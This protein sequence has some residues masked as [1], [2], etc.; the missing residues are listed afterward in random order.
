MKCADCKTP[1]A[2]EAATKSIPACH[3]E[4]FVGAINAPGSLFRVARDLELETMEW[5]KGIPAHMTAFMSAKQALMQWE[6]WHKR[7]V[8]HFGGDDGKRIT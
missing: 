2:C 1:R 3:A 5:R 4:Q 6:R 8:E 7:L